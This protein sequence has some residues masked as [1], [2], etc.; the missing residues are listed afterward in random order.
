M[1]L[2]S[3][4]G[5][6]MPL[7]KRNK[8]L[9][10]CLLFVCCQKV[11]LTVEP[12]ASGF[13]VEGEENVAIVGT[14]E[15]TRQRPYT[16]TD[17]LALELT[18]NDTAWVIG[19]MVGTAR[20]TMNNAIFSIDAD[21]GSNI[22]LSSDSLCTDISSCIPV[23][24]SSDKWKSQLSL[25]TNKAHFRKCLLLRGIPATY[26]KRKG[27]EKVLTGLWLDGFDISSV[28]PTEWGSIEI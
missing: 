19:Y 18:P 28:A 22:L 17:I 11:D 12:E 3:A 10:L 20:T 13:A 25:P 8:L 7:P 27:L 21:N 24:L 1:C 26:L 15:G 23:R 9:L 2:R 5:C 4:R 16:A 6:W 14:G